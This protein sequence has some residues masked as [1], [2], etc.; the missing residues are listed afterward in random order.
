MNEESSGVPLSTLL[1]FGSPGF[2]GLTYNLAVVG[3]SK[4]VGGAW[5]CSNRTL[6]PRPPELTLAFGP[7]RIA[8]L[9]LLLLFLFWWSPPFFWFY[10]LLNKWL[11]PWLHI[12]PLHRWIPNLYFRVQD[13]PWKPALSW[14]GGLPVVVL[15]L[16]ILRQEDNPVFQAPWATKMSNFMSIWHKPET[17]ERNEPQL[18]KSLHKIGL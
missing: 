13:W 12:Q 10:T 8:T 15:V 7:R 3:A 5:L 6:C 14:H 11:L 9:V 16:G 18:R 2:L 4:C 17:S 1:A